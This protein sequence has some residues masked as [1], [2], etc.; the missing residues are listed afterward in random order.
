M[1][2]VNFLINY[3]ERLKTAIDSINY[4]EVIVDDSQLI[5]F[6][7][8]RSLEDK[9]MLFM[10]LPDF[11]NSGRNVDDIKK[12]TDTLI[13]VLQKT[14]YSSVSHAEFLQIMQE[15]LISARAIETKMIADM[16]DYTEAGCL[17]MKD[18]NVPSISIQ[19]VWGLAEC[20]GWSI[21]FNFEAD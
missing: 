12:R 13:L 16:F 5:H 3:S 15:T 8:E 6:L 4:K 10:V 9:H 19:P 21:E 18:L 2:D 17:Y 14:D 7:E 20:N 11:S 1:I